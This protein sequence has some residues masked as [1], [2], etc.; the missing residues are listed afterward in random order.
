MARGGTRFSGSSEHALD[1]KGRFVVPARF[2]ELLGENFM[3]S[4]ASPDQCLA[5]HPMEN[6]EVLCDQL[7]A[8]VDKDPEYRKRVRTI[9]AHAHQVQCD[10]QGRL[11]IPPVLRAFAEL[12]R[13]VT[14]IGTIRR[15][16]LWSPAKLGKLE[17]G[18]PD[19]AAIAVELGLY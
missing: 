8:R 6:W 13:S 19:A 3:I 2:R 4:P 14:A 17:P 5:L 15:V 7:E 18:G 16:E 1:D 9:T 11:V 10:N 12:E